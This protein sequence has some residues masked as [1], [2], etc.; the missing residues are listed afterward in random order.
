MFRF[1]H[2]RVFDRFWKRELDIEDFSVLLAVLAEAG[3][4]TGGFQEFLAD[5]GRRELETIHEAA[6]EAGVFGVPTFVI[7]GE[8]FWGREHLP[9]VRDILRAG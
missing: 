6:H 2:D 9:D 7:D 4:D 3:A 5:E 1:Y 8:L